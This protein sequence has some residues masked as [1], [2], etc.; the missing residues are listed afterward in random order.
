MIV[1]IEVFLNDVMFVSGELLGGKSVPVLMGITRLP[2]DQ[3]LACLVLSI[4]ALAGTIFSWYTA[5]VVSEKHWL[6]FVN[7]LVQLFVSLTLSLSLLLSIARGMHYIRGVILSLIPAFCVVVQSLPQ[8]ESTPLV[9]FLAACFTFYY[10]M[11]THASAGDPDD[12]SPSVL[13][14][15]GS[16]DPEAVATR[17]WDVVF[18]SLQLF[19]LAFYA[20]VQH[21][22]TKIS[23]GRDVRQLVAASRFHADYPRY[24][25]FVGLVAALIRISTWYS[26][27]LFQN[28]ALHVILE[29]DHAQ[30]GWDWACCVFLTITLLFSAC[31]TAT[32]IREQVLPY[33]NVSAEASRLKLVV[34]ALS[35]AALYRQRDP[36]VAFFA[37]VGLSV[38]SL[39]T[40]SA[41]LK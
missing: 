36:Q 15:L 29:N 18:R 3:F 22:P 12:A 7:R 37:V 27:C 10:C 17:V 23:Y 35:L 13:L 21:A 25:L 26:V 28:N 31:W 8:R 34:G 30:G 32:Q 39:V 14:G 33:F 41:T 9:A 16:D 11:T 2:I 24:A 4:G 40:T 6:V 1:P 5:Q 19:G 38:L 20:C